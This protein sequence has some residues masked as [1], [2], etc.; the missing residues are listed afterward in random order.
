[1]GAVDGLAVLVGVRRLDPPLS[2]PFVDAVDVGRE[3]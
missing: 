3:K 2:E 1:V